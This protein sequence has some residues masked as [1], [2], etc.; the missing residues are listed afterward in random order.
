MGC[1]LW[2]QLLKG[3]A[4]AEHW[5]PDKTILDELPAQI[6]QAGFTALS[7]SVIGKGH[8]LWHH[9]VNLEESSHKMPLYEAGSLAKPIAALAAL[10]L[11]QKDLLDLDRPLMEY[12]TLP[13]LKDNAEAQKITA[14][15][16]LSHSTGLQNWRFSNN[17]KLRL[18]FPPGEGFSYSGEGYV[19]LQRVMEQL[20]GQGYARYTQDHIFEPLRMTSSSLAYQEDLFARMVPGYKRD[21]SMGDD[22]GRRIGSA[23]LQ[24]ASEEQSDLSDWKFDKVTEVY[25]TIESNLPPLPVFISPNAAGSL[26]STTADYAKILHLMLHDA[27]KSLGIKGSLQKTLLRSTSSVNDTINWGLGWGLESN[28]GVVFHTCETRFYKGLALF[29][30]GSGNG[31]VILTNGANGDQVYD[32]LARSA[33][34]MKLAALDTF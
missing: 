24:E 19:W 16:V 23:M 25:A 14:R 11:A 5:I 9:T 15:Q 34:S 20:S 7:I 1:T 30:V 8:D 27:G 10:Q 28:S 13:D 2:P 31:L 4:R 12:Y 29:E 3:T 32:G 6:K 22:Y 26:I 17:D 21:G 33:T 18:R